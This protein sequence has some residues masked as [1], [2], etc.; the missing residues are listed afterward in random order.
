MNVD[1]PV[2]EKITIDEKWS[3]VR[4][5]AGDYRVFRY[6][7]PMPHQIKNDQ[8]AMFWRILELE[9]QVAE[10]RKAST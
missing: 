2:S 9:K 8:V 6:D 3:M 10:L 5:A 4:S 7:E 1:E